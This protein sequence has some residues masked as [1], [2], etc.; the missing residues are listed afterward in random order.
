MTTAKR[1]RACSNGGNCGFPFVVGALFAL[2][3]L[4]ILWSMK[5]QLL[6]PPPPPPTIPKQ[7]S[8][9]VLVPDPPD[10]TFY[11]DPHLNYSI[12]NPLH[13]WDEKRREWVS[14]HPGVAAPAVFVVTGSQPKPCRN[15]IGD[16]LLLRCFKNK[17][18]YCRI[19]NCEVYYNTLHL[20]PKMDSYWAKL[21]ALRAAMMAHPEA[22]WF[23]WLDADA[24]ITDMDFSIPLGRYENHNLVVH[25][26][27]NVVY[28]E[29]NKS[30]TGLN[31]GSVLIRNCQWSMDLMHAWAQMGPISPHYESLGKVLKRVFK[32]K[33]FPLPDD[34]SSLIY[35]LS[36]EREKWGVKTYLEEGYELESYWLSK[37]GKMEGMKEGYLEMEEEVKGLRR[38]HAEKV[39]L[40]YGK[41]REGYL[42]DYGGGTMMMRRPFVTHF[43][44]CQPC[45]G[46]HNPQYKG[47]TCWTEMQRALNFADNQVLRNYGFLRN[48]LTSSSVT[49]VPYDF[50]RS[51]QSRPFF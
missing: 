42:R 50:P 28:S 1:K 9:V 18:D 7:D 4:W 8:E 47:D 13:N 19:H 49:Q 15:S 34:Q 5:D 44:G 10:R 6:K 23:W 45:S 2:L 29:S 37:L 30:W 38:R 24:V 35:L 26:W 16:H 36:T 31:A 17:V 14:L 11:D 22:E 3:T 25:G 21:Q 40:W 20:N 41:L 12:E 48:S 32:D 46:D 43:T 39:A 51:T 27:S 33:P